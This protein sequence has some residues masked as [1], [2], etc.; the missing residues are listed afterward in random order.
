MTNKV[1]VSVLPRI[2]KQWTYPKFNF[3]YMEIWLYFFIQSQFCSFSS[4]QSLCSSSHPAAS[5]AWYLLYTY[6]SGSQEIKWSYTS[7][8]IPHQCHNDLTMCCSIF[9]AALKSYVYHCWHIVMF[10]ITCTCR[11]E[12]YCDISGRAVYL[13]TSVHMC[14][15]CLLCMHK[16]NGNGFLARLDVK[17]LRGKFNPKTCSP[18]V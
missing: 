12:E 18:S 2:M 5:V 17:K 16:K 3:D 13:I 9:L 6:E 15:T 4:F 1:L 8:N 11:L 10:H 14:Y 7:K